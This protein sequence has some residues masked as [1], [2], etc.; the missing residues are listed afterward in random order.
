MLQMK[1]LVQETIRGHKAFL[2][3]VKYFEQKAAKI[4]HMD[5]E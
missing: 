4:L 1:A 3:F 2:W 5:N